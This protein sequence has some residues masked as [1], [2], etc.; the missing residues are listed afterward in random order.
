MVREI[1]EARP[2]RETPAGTIP[3]RAAPCL[4]QRSHV[5]KLAPIRDPKPGH[6][7]VRIPVHTRH[8]LDLG[9]ALAMMELVDAD[10]I[11]EEQSTFPPHRRRGEEVKEVRA[12]PE[13]LA[14]QMDLADLARVLR[15]TPDVGERFIMRAGE[16][17]EGD[18]LQVVGE[19]AMLACCVTR[20]S[21]S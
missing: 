19:L 13:G 17:L 20:E 10:G 5:A 9:L 18:G 16:I 15:M 1:P 2:L 3:P 21:R 4:T 12:D 8:L 11:D 6:D 7:L 14:V